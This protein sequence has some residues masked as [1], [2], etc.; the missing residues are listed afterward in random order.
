MIE[1]QVDKKELER[2]TWNMCD[3][4]NQIIA[5]N[6]KMKQCYHSIKYLDKYW[7]DSRFDL[8]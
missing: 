2:N 7:F 5:R 8:W 3:S 1:A 4:M 6:S